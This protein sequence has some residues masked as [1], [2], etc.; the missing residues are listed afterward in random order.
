MLKKL[1]LIATV[2]T[3]LFSCKDDTGLYVYNDNLFGTKVEIEV[4]NDSLNMATT[5]WVIPGGTSIKSFPIIEHL[6]DKIIWLNKEGLK[7]TLIVAE[8]E[9]KYKKLKFIKI[10]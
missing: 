5:S 1:I 8:N 4:T 10:E 2:S 6:D 7:D 9:L 3:I